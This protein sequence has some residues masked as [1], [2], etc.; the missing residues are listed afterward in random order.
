MRAHSNRILTRTGEHCLAFKITLLRKFE[1]K[2][3]SLKILTNK[4][5]VLY[6]VHNLSIVI[7]D[8]VIVSVEADPSD[9]DHH[10]DHRTGPWSWEFQNGSA[11]I[12]PELYLVQHCY[13]YHVR[14]GA[15]MIT[16]LLYNRHNN[17]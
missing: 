11:F 12:L 2:F 15:V 3:C 13:C 4:L 10:L 6:N 14:D 9:S 16:T 5:C 1:L 7:G 17:L 8:S